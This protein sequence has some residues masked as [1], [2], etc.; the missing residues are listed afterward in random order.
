M[1]RII[2]RGIES[3]STAQVQITFNRLDE[4][5]FAQYFVFVYENL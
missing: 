2:F 3:L 5:I 4:R 1:K